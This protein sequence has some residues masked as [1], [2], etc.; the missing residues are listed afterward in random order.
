MKR[1]ATAAV[2]VPLALAAVFR[3][4]GPWFFLL[5]VVLIDWGAIEFVRLLRPAL[6]GAPLWLVPAV[7]PLAALLL[8]LALGDGTQLASPE[9]WLVAAAAA[10]PL[11][12]GAAVLFLRT[13]LD[14]VLGTLGALAFGIPYFALPI[15]SLYWLQQHD[16][17]VVFLLCAIVWLGDT[18]ALYAGSYLGKRHM[19]PVVSPKKTWEGAAA[20]FLI[21]VASTAVWSAWQYSSVRWPLLAAGAG[22]A[23]AAQVGDLVESLIKRASGAKDSGGILP[24]HGGMLDRMDAMLF[25]APALL[26]GL[27]LIGVMG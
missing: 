19:A 10:L 23:V 26:V 5:C 1:L 18:A 24:G 16:P 9:R 4:P 21:G 22:T 13:P 25:A 15:A 6:P 2:A 27:W 7:A 12:V 8:A 20:G 14:E 17:W 3:L 11:G